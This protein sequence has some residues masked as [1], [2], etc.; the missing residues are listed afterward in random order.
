MNEYVCVCAY[1]RACVRA[2]VCGCACLRAC[3][4][5]CV[6]VCVR[7]CIHGGSENINLHSIVDQ[8]IQLQQRGHRTRKHE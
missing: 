5:A 7:V 8:F 6:R 4:H 3:V 1:V 2:C